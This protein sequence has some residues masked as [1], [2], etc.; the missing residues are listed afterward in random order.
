[1]HANTMRIAYRMHTQHE[2]INDGRQRTATSDKN[3]NEEDHEPLLSE[4][5]PLCLTH[6]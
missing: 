6:H 3:V 5:Q 2:Q 4:D 1:M